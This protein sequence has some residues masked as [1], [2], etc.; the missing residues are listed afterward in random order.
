MLKLIGSLSCIWLLMA[1]STMAQVQP[2]VL[3]TAGQ[4]LRSGV[5]YYIL[6]AATDTAGGLT[7]L[8]R[9]RSCPS[10]VGQEPLTPVVS[11]GLPVVFT[12]Y[13][14]GETIV[15]ESSSFIVKFSA[16]STC[17]KST[18]WSLTARD[19]ARSRR[20]IVTGRGAYFMITKRSNLYYLAFCPA[21]ICNTCRFDCGTAGITIENG[22][23]F[24]TLDG[25]VF[26]FRFR[27]AQVA[28]SM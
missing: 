21:D 19:P 14:T 5:E 17:V 15:R 9:N 2:P 6:P 11:Q 27:R 3:D 22:K 23:R 28:I 10:F 24:L 7:L 12:P 16:A 25:P 13:A 8:S 20:N 4:P 26:P 1:I 18:E